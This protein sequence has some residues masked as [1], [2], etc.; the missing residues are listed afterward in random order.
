MHHLSFKRQG[1]KRLLEYHVYTCRHNAKPETLNKAAAEGK[2]KLDKWKAIISRQL[3]HTKEWLVYE[4]YMC[5]MNG[6]VTAQ[7]AK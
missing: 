7:N 3:V 6:K 5:K 4:A 2:K 1:P